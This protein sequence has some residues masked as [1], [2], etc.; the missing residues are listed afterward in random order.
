MGALAKLGIVIIVVVAAWFF[1]GEILGFLGQ[2]A[3]FIFFDFGWFWF[4]LALFLLFKQRGSQPI[5]A[6]DSLHPTLSDDLKFWGLVIGL[7]VLVLLFGQAVW[8]F[9]APLV[10][11]LGEALRGLSPI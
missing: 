11:G 10:Y 2:A 7:G 1:G 4:C 8:N 3:R 9:F 6:R 5:A